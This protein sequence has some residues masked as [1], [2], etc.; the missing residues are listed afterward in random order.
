M[1]FDLTSSCFFF[2]GNPFKQSLVLQACLVKGSMFVG[3]QNNPLQNH[4]SIRESSMFPGDRQRCQGKR[5]HRASWPRA[6][7]VSACAFS[8]AFSAPPALPQVRTWRGRGANGAR[9]WKIPWGNEMGNLEVNR[10]VFLFLW[11]VFFISILFFK[12]RLGWVVGFIWFIPVRTQN[13][14]LQLKELK[15]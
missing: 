1:V 12:G 3:T 9:T 15:G 2:T 10:W 5:S 7:E 14:I 4:W 11:L 13:L 6:F 8:G